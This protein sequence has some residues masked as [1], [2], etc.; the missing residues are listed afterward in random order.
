MPYPGLRV[1]LPIGLY[2]IMV[3]PIYAQPLQ[4]S[5]RVSGRIHC[6]THIV[7]NILSELSVHIVN[8]KQIIYPPR[9]FSPLCRIMD[10]TPLPQ[11]LSE[12]FVPAKSPWIGVVVIGIDLKNCFMTSCKQMQNLLGKPGHRLFYSLWI[13]ATHTIE[14]PPKEL[15]RGAHT[16]LSAQGGKVHGVKVLGFLA[17]ENIQVVGKISA[18]QVA[19]KA[20]GHQVFLEAHMLPA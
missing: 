12:G 1:V 8:C 4:K 20:V 6:V 9:L 16:P 10:D 11:Q 15:L 18:V 3:E 7:D 19:L 14:K 5:A 17:N 2:A 13:R